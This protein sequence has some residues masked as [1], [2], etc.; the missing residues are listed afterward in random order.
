LDLKIIKQGFSYLERER[1]ETDRDSGNDQEIEFLEIDIGVFQEIKTLFRRSKLC[2]GD[3]KFFLIRRSKLLSNY[4]E[5]KSLIL[6][7]NIL[8][9]LVDTQ[10]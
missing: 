10:V 7:F 2:S 6:S 9:N 5:I 1:G 8:N 3:Q 4:Q